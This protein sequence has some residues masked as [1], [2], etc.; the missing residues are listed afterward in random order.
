[1]AVSGRPVHYLN[2]FPNEP[3]GGRAENCVDMATNT[4]TGSWADRNCG[5]QRPFMCRKPL[6]GKDLLSVRTLVLISL[7]H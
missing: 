5:E 6:P 4:Y 2:W 3:N 1:M 7:K